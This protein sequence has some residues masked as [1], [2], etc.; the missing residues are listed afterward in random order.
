MITTRI[1]QQSLNI[2]AVI[3]IASCCVAV[4]FTARA[5]FSEINNDFN[6]KN[7]VGDDTIHLA[8]AFAQAPRDGRWAWHESQVSL[9]SEQ[10]N[11]A[12]P[13]SLA[14]KLVG[15][16]SHK[17]CERA[18]A[19]VELGSR[20]YSYSCGEVANLPGVHIMRVLTD[21]IVIKHKGY[22]ETVH[23]GKKDAG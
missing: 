12:P 20:Q 14:L 6:E 17:D 18:L 13:S 11:N 23:I 7:S 21:R 22:F 8:A 9:S 2:I 15:V 16:V 1:R 5:P 19:I 10:V 4:Y 3:M